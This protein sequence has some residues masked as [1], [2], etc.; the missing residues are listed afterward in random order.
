M[1]GG[2]LIVRKGETRS[3]HLR[4]IMPPNTLATSKGRMYHFLLQHQPGAHPSAFHMTLTADGRTRS[5]AIADPNADWS[6]AE[7]IQD[8]PFSPIPLPANPF[9]VVKPGRWLEP[10]T[11]LGRRQ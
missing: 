2:Y 1:F 10:G 5:W 7:S 11:Y 9:P 6:T 8:R 4:Y 3:V